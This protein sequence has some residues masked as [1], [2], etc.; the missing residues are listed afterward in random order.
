[1]R[2]VYLSLGSNLGDRAGNLAKAVGLLGG[3]GIRVL[4]ES[5]RYETA[6]REVEDQPWFLNSVAEVETDLAPA[7]LL[8][9]V[10]AIERRMGRE[11]SIP[12]GPRPIDIDILIYRGEIVD[13]PELR[14]PH[15]AM[16][17]RRFVLEPLADLA[18]DL[19]HPLNGLTVREMLAGVGEQALRRW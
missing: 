15:A 13:T 3:E 16:H 1:M 8:A 18:P 6:P 12:K 10:L 14:I 19:V 7:G 11:R 2:P 9:R 17:E 4:R 5:P